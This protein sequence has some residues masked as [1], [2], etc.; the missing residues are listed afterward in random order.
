MY[1]LRRVLNEYWN[2]EDF[3]V[4]ASDGY[5]W[6]PKYE[7]V[8]DTD[9]L[10]EHFQNPVYASMNETEMEECLKRYTEIFMKGREGFR[11]ITH[12]RMFFIPSMLT[13]FI[14][15]ATFLAKK[16]IMKR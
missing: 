13:C 11:W 1:R 4:Y 9:Y 14:G 10:L 8:V 12:I 2:D 5:R 7:V 3:I 6:N 15:I 16:K